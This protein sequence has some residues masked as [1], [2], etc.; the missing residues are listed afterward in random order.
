[1]KYICS[2]CKIEKE[3]DQFYVSP[4]GRRDCYCRYRHREIERLREGSVE[5]ET[6]RKNKLKRHQIYVRELKNKPCTD[7]RD[8]YPYFV[9]DLDHIGEKLKEISRMVTSGLVCIKAESLNCEPVCANCHRIRTFEREPRLI[10]ELRL[11][12]SMSQGVRKTQYG[13]AWGPAGILSGK[14]KR[15]LTCQKD[16]PVEWFKEK[17]DNTEVY[18]PNCLPCSSEYQARWYELH[19]DARRMAAQERR[20]IQSKE[21]REYILFLKEKSVCT[22]C[23]RKWPSYVLDF[24]HVSEGKTEIVSRMARSSN[25]EAVIKEI[26]KC[27]LV[28]ANC[29]RYRTQVRILTAGGHEELIVPNPWLEI[30]RTS[31]FIE[32]L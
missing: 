17:R 22:D 26:A 28:C 8:V 19:A 24:D 20:T 9:M 32:A 27:E 25:L 5:R 6:H 16:L 23:R 29:H 14:N 1:M 31:D 4:K 7:C 18:L 10:D 13:E 2:R 12:T 3:S 15:C 11:F 21:N 30:Y